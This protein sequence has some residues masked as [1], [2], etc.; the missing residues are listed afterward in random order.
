MTA[1]HH[2]LTLLMLLIALAVAAPVSAL[3][4]PVGKVIL[5]VTG[6]IAVSNAGDRADFDLAMIQ[7]LPQHRIETSTPWY[8]GVTRFA[9][10]LIADLLAAVGS[11]GT[12]L[13]TVALNDYKVDIPVADLVTH[14]AILAWAH[15]D[16]PMTVRDKGPLFIVYPYDAEPVLQS[17]RFFNRS[18]WQLRLIEVR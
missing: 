16:K 12:V 3:Q 10:P 4:A 2:L 14:G 5:S 9:G 11:R 6:K 18:P 15:D 7:A 1:R 13:A 8:H 17:E